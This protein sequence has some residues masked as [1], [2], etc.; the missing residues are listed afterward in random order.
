MIRLPYCLLLALVV[1][2]AG[3]AGS[4]SSPSQE[5][6]TSTAPGATDGDIAAPSEEA[7]VDDEVAV[8]LIVQPAGADLVSLAATVRNGRQEAIGVLE[9]L[10]GDVRPTDEA[11]TGELRV[12]ADRS[13]DGDEAPPNA[14]VLVIGAGSSAT[15]ESNGAVAVDPAIERLRV[16]VELLPTQGAAEDGA[17]T[18]VTLDDAEPVVLGCSAPT[19]IDGSG[20]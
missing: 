14:E 7:S 2:C 16:C 13:G 9:E 6:R 3:C 15:L 17:R 4:P 20:G 1:G 11:G 8:E 18:T 12:L 10:G 19:P 5:P